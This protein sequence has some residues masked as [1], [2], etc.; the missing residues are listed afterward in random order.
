MGDTDIPPAGASIRVTAQGIG[1]YAGTGDARPEISAVYRIV[2][3]NFS[4]VR[5]KAAAKS[6]Q[7][8]RP[9][10]LT[11]DDLTITMNRGAEP[12]VLGKDYVIVEDSYI[13]HTKKGTARVTLRGIGNYGGEK[14]ISYTIGAKTLLWWVK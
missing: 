11:A 5:V 9:V 14:T 6:Y 12:L 13:N 7:D 4:G 3:T 10:T 1:A 2:S 8:G